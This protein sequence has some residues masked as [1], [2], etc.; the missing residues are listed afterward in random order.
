RVTPVSRKAEPRLSGAVP[1]RRPSG[2]GEQGREGDRQAPVLPA[3]ADVRRRAPRRGAGGHRPGRREGPEGHGG[4]DEGADAQGAR[5]GGGEGGLRGS[6]VGA[7]AEVRSA[8]G[9]FTGAGRG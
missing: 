3:G 9:A 4:G 5:P 7:P 8:P 1:R 6:E 2:A